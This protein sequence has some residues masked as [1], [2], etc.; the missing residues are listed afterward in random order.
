MKAFSGTQKLLITILV[1][2]TAVAR[3]QDPNY[4]KLSDVE[5]QIGVKS[6]ATGDTSLNTLLKLVENPPEHKN[7]DEVKK[8]AQRITQLSEKVND[9]K[10]GSSKLSYKKLIL[11][12]KKLNK[13]LAK[14]KPSASRTTKYSKD[15]FK[16][17]GKLSASVKKSG[18]KNAA[19][20]RQTFS[21]EELQK[22][23][24][25]AHAA[26]LSEKEYVSATKCQGC[27][28]SH[29][30]QWSMSQHAYAQLS[31]IYMAMQNAINSKTSNTNG[32]FCIR[33]HNQVGM[34]KGEP[35]FMSNLGRHPAS[36]EGITCVVCHRIAPKNPKGK[37]LGDLMPLEYG[38]VSGRIALR[39]GDI[40]DVVFGPKPDDQVK[41]QI[42]SA[43]S[44]NIHENVGQF[45]Q[46]STSSFCGTC[47]D[48]NLF[49]GFRLEEAFSEYKNSP[50]AA[51][52]VSCQDCHMGKIQ[53]KPIYDENG[54]VSVENYHKGHIATSS[55]RLRKMTDHTF[56]GPDYSV[57]Q[58]AL[59]PFSDD[60]ANAATIRDWLKFKFDKG[61]GSKRW[62]E[63]TGKEKEGLLHRSFWPDEDKLSR[64]MYSVD[65]EHA[66]KTILAQFDKLKEARR[67]RNQVLKNGYKLVNYQSR[68]EF[69]PE[70]ITITQANKKGIEFHVGVKNGTD[71]HNAPTGFI[72]ERL[73]WLNVEVYKEGID[74]PIFLSGD[75]DPN[76]DVRDAHSTFVHNGD[77][78]W[79][80]ADGVGAQRLLTTPKGITRE[81]EQVPVEADLQLFNLQSKFITRNIRGGEREQILAINHSVDTK[82]FIRPSTRST[83]LTGQP[84]GARIHRLSLPP[85]STRKVS[86]DI[87]DDLLKGAGN[88]KI[89]VRFK[90]A[91]LPVNLV[92]EVSEVGFDYG[93]TPK[94][95]ARRLVFGFHTERQ[96]IRYYA[97]DSPDELKA[98]TSNSK[99]I[100]KAQ[101]E[102]KHQLAVVSTDDQQ[103]MLDLACVTY[104]AEEIANKKNDYVLKLI[105]EMENSLL[106]KSSDR[107]KTIAK[108]LERAPLDQLIEVKTYLEE[109]SYTKISEEEKSKIKK[110]IAV[111][112]LNDDMNKYWQDSKVRNYVENGLL[113]PKVTGHETLYEVEKT[114]EV[115]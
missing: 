80:I 13:E 50:A 99:Y 89:I 71:G 51:N 90:S 95:V 23:A 33:C 41:Q 52:E 18:S 7:I 81:D 115:K 69:G 2:L 96:Q 37:T 91:M 100:K 44:E 103:K 70:S 94:E 108:E 63:E 46:I 76:G 72:G 29:F 17:L 20:Q 42:D 3:A 113:I 97:I 21:Q 56:S 36:R 77:S 38:K 64:W 75:L 114:V 86:Y 66:R 107:F 19:K 112:D 31:P 83:V 85:K 60:I 4:K 30:E 55:T 39:K 53:G 84:A 67:K 68:K 34:N 49:N 61:W 105:D 22:Q 57:I 35:T 25:E 82:P 59:F 9:K 93:M 106:W 27:H 79:K 54:K 45:E 11:N 10:L 14:T 24:R 1:F 28:P 8:I 92:N 5:A 26:L 111:I 43:G 98:V 110:V 78:R 6:N 40:K 104:Y 101:Q 16:D 12:L 74:E 109:K 58:P 88:Y 47:H 102:L 62:E 65:R 87:D 15:I 48:V 32:D 73:V